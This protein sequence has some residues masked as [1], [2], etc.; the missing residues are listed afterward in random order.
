MRSPRPKNRAERRRARRRQRRSIL[1]SLCAAAASLF[2]LQQA[3]WADAPPEDISIA[4]S[5]AY[6]DERPL[7]SYKLAPGST[8]ERYHVDS[9]QVSLSSPIGERFS[10]GVNLVYETMS[11]A[12]PWW[13]QPGPDGELLQAMSGATVSDERVDVSANGSYYLDS[14]RVGAFFGVSDENDYRAIYGGMNGDYSVNDKNTTLS[15]GISFSTD[16]ITPTGGGTG[17]RVEK[18]HKDSLSLYA[19][20]S[21]ILGRSTNLQSTVSYRYSTGF[22]SDPYKRAWVSDFVP[23][24]GTVP[25]ARP[26]SRHQVAWLTQLRQHIETLNASIHLDYQFY[27]DDWKMVSHTIEFRWYQNLF[28]DLIQVIPSI[29]YYS[30]GHPFFYAPVYNAGRSDGLA[31]SDYR[32]SPFG[33]LS[34]GLR[35]Q[36]LV[37]DWP[38]N[39]DWRL[40]A[41]YEYYVSSADYALGNVR[42]ANP[43]LVDYYVLYATLE[44]RF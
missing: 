19:G 2:G 12:T 8:S 21:Q 20:I 18:A 1:T 40:G 7:A 22:L 28:D 41:S 35:G 13:V 42:A 23:G 34:Y 6:Y 3:S 15:T 43:G 44:T 33:A 9:H 16:D 36:V 26:D 29:R 14:G 37:E 10:L 25:D 4:Y 5:F 39:M 11:G 30:Q 31:A 27:Y 24:G 32:L 17:G 38:G